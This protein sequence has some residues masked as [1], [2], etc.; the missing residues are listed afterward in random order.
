MK[1]CGQID[2]VLPHM[3]Y[4]DVIEIENGGHFM[5]ADQAKLISKIINEKVKNV[6]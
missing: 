2:K 5:V 4:E 1:I 6:T 3:Q